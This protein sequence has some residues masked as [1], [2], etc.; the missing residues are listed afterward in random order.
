VNQAK[1]PIFWMAYLVD[2]C[3]VSKIKLRDYQTFS[4]RHLN[5]IEQQACCSTWSWSLHCEVCLLQMSKRPLIS[6]SPSVIRHTNV[7]LK[8]HLKLTVTIWV[9]L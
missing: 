7:S 5:H 9:Q 2:L 1:M 4:S 8:N 6:A 3:V